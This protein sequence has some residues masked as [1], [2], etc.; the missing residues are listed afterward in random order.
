MAIGFA[1][2]IFQF[3]VKMLQFVQ[4]LKQEISYL[5]NLVQILQDNYENV[6]EKFQQLENALYDLGSDH[7]WDIS[8]PVS[9]TTVTLQL[10]Q[11]DIIDLCSDSEED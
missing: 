1:N 6:L 9:P 10:K 3:P 11:Q 4:Q 8:P 5:Q 7:R 2:I